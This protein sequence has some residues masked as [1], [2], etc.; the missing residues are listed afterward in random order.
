ML[1][2]DFLLQL[3]KQRYR[4]V[5]GKIISLDWNEYPL[6]E[7]TGRVTQGSVNLDGTSSVRR[8]CSLSLVAKD[9]DIND[10]YWGLKT[11]F[12]LEI[13]LRNTINKNYPEIIWLP[14]G[15]YII[16]QFSTSQSTNN[17]TISVQGKDKMSLLNGDV[18][19]EIYAS[20]DFGQIEETDE[21]G[22]TTITK[23]P[24]KNIIRESVHEYA[25]EPFHNIVI[26]DLDDYGI[27]LLEY[28]G[29]E[30][31]YMFIYTS[32]SE[33]GVVD[34]VANMTLDGSKVCWKQNADGSE[35][36]T[37][38]DS[39]IY[40]DL[41]N[42]DSNDIITT[43]PDVIRVSQSSNNYYKVAKFE[44]GN[45]VGYRTTPLIY[46]DD[47]I[48]GAGGTLTSMLDKLIKNMLSDFEYFYDTDGR[49]IF[50]KKPTYISTSWNSIKNTEDDVY[51]ENMALSSSYVFNFE[52]GSLVIN[53][54]N[55]PNLGNVKNDYSIWGKRKGVS[56]VELPIHLRYAIDHK[57]TQYTTIEITEEEAEKYNAIYGTN[58][59]SQNSTTYSV[60][61]WDWREII[62][63]MALDYRKHNHMDE[64][65]PKVREANGEL[66]PSGY[67]GYEQYY[68]DLEG[69]W[70]QL[71]NPN[72]EPS[73]SLISSE[74]ASAQIN[75]IYID[76]SFIPYKNNSSIPREQLYVYKDGVLK[77][78]LDYIK[79]KDELI[80]NVYFYEEGQYFLLTE[81]I[82]NTRSISKNNMYYIERETAAGPLY[83]SLLEGYSISKIKDYLYYIDREN[84]YRVMDLNE[85]CKSLYFDDN[86]LQPTIYRQACDNY[87][88][89]LPDIYTEYSVYYYTQYYDY[90]LDEDL[91]I[92][93]RYWNKAVSE[94]PETLN[95]WFDFID[96]DSEL[97]KFSVP[98][99]GAR[100]KV[101]S[102]SAAKGIYFRDTPMVLFVN[103]E[104]WKQEGN[105]DP[106]YTYIKLAAG[107]EKMFNISTQ[108][109][110][111]MN[112]FDETL[113]SHSYC[114]ESISLTTIPVYY[115]EPNTRI[116]VYNKESNING[117]Y[118]INS[119]SIPLT[120]NGTM[121]ISATKAVERRIL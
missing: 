18:S 8:T 47:L 93:E 58:M 117:E 109:K 4:E 29:S 51:A 86:I 26:N 54:N 38:I 83:I 95:F 22:V 106:G 67:T 65:L 40:D 27:E 15:V 102:N 101:V 92:R 46:P 32:K 112:I 104:Q 36:K 68:V 60:E 70:R 30:P 44:Y 35:T 6:E 5:F 71:Y 9:L 59:R 111:A 50:Q 19:G 11:K 24:I 63:Q 87:G 1:D 82:M 119:L 7:I 90:K 64:F 107:M 23:K 31:I 42:I 75:Y 13:G 21:N 16:S 62:Y 79:V 39:L 14:M 57:P 121:S 113:Y 56:G 108:G 81:E 48:I 17:Y 85:N 33:N 80:N 37:T 53:A 66:Y 110:S 77:S 99:I 43:I 88:V 10:Y 25:G 52:D 97:D 3:T 114:T 118:I 115:L 49:F 28:Q 116:S 34:M 96:T 94:A 45:T 2:K 74:E 100:A 72:P 89:E 76:F 78:L 98:A 41:V 61:N 105:K 84:K 69:F 73:Y 55:N 20:V 103:E 120:Y 91:D 12:K